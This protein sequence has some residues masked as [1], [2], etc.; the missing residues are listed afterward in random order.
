MM[1]GQ[2][3]IKKVFKLLVLFILMLVYDLNWKNIFSLVISVCCG[4][5]ER[6]ISN[7]SSNK[8]RS[9]GLYI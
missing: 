4:C 5:I 6:S 1:N 3:N 9:L 8:L 2:K 7:L